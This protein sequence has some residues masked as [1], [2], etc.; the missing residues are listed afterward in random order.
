MIRLLIIGLVVYFIYRLLKGKSVS[1]PESGRGKDE[2]A[3]TPVDAELIR[4]P[5]CGA[6]FLRQQGVPAKIDGKSLYFCSETCRNT[7]IQRV[8][9]G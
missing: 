9:S 4:E 2:E 1:F 7:Y 5:Q 8:K 3:V 6:Y